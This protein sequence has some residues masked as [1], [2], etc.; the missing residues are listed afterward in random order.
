MVHDRYEA[1]A[2]KSGGPPRVEVGDEKRPGY[3]GRLDKEVLALIEPMMEITYKKLEDP[4]LAKAIAK[5]CHNLDSELM[6]EEFR[7]PEARVRII[8]AAL[9]ST[10]GGK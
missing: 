3:M 4:R 2:K 9:S 10:L 5:F 7:T 8:T 1:K 6:C